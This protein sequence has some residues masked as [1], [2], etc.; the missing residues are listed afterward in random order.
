MTGIQPHRASLIRQR[1]L[2]RRSLAGWLERPSALLEALALP[3]LLTTALWLALPERDG[4]KLGLIA[5][6]VSVALASAF[7]VSR[8]QPGLVFL[9]RRHLLPGDALVGLTCSAL[10]IGSAQAML[11]LT[12][13]GLLDAAVTTTLLPAMLALVMP[14]A[15]A[16]LA[17]GLAAGRRPLLAIGLIAALVTLQIIAAALFQANGENGDVLLTRLAEFSPLH[18]AGQM[19][20]ALIEERSLLRPLAFL[21]GQAL[22]FL[23][24]ARV[25]LRKG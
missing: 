17:C 13:L 6:L 8:W 10:V 16:G 18:W 23:G 21:L 25:F 4:A 11:A 7:Q 2:T 1:V 19:H 24:L 3:V 14:A 20:R 12:T 9:T 22:L 5:V 15:A